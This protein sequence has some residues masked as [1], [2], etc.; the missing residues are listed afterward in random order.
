MQHEQENR[1]NMKEEY[2]EIEDELEVQ[3]HLLCE[4]VIGPVLRA[5]YSLSARTLSSPISFAL[6]VYEELSE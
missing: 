5:F 3:F 1:K 4:I 2:K 6:A